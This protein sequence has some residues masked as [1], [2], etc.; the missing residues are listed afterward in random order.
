MKNLSMREIVVLYM[1]RNG[2]TA[3]C[4]PDLDCGCTLDD[5]I[6]CGN[7]MCNLDDCKVAYHKKCTPDACNNTECENKTDG[8]H[9]PCITM[10]KP[11]N[12]RVR[13]TQ[14]SNRVHYNN[15]V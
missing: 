3:L 13:K 14:K 15:T 5:F 1:K 12:R 9:G 8:V 11:R 2:F 6:P 4:N 7:D 10:R